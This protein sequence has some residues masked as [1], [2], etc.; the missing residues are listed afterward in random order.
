MFYFNALAMEL[1]KNIFLAIEVK[2]LNEGQGSRPTFLNL[3]RKM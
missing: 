3:N 1:Q 2:E